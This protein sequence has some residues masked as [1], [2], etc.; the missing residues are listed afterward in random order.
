MSIHDPGNPVGDLMNAIRFTSDTPSNEHTYAMERLADRH[1]ARMAE[2]R[3]DHQV[4]IAQIVQQ[5]RETLRE[6]ALILFA[7]QE[8]T[9]RHQSL[10]TVLRE[11][12]QMLI[13]DNASLREQAEMLFPEVLRQILS[14]LMGSQARLKQAQNIASGKPR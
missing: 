13:S 4:K 14:E 3:A 5:Q 2:L 10:K 6:M 1:D 8:Q 11:M 9:V 12:R 7:T